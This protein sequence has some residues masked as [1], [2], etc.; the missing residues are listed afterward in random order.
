MEQLFTN[1]SHAVE[2]APLVALSAAVVWGILSIVLSPCHLA[3]IPLIVGFISEQGQVT[4]KRAFWTS[5][6]FAVGILVTIAAIGAI[7]AAAGRMMGDVGRYGN[8]FV[9]LIFFVVGLHLVGVIP[10]NFSGA[11]PVGMKRKGLL[12]ALILGLV[13]GIALGPCTFAYMAPMLAVTFKLGGAAPFY[14]ASLLLAYGMGHCSVIILAGTSTE[15]VQRFLNWNEQSK[16]LAAVK[17]ICGI[18]VMLGGVWLIYTA[19]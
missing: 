6:L 7:T 17:I 3:S 16:G 14:A 1:L 15:V 9:A 5:T 2:G 8:Y 12:A 4:A 19:P 18:L 13:F 10:L 11:G